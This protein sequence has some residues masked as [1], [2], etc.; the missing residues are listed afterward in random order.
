MKCR[1]SSS[2]HP[3]V[4][5]EFYFCPSVSLKFALG[6]FC[7]APV[8]PHGRTQGRGQTLCC[9]LAVGPVPGGGVQAATANFKAVPGMN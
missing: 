1:L 9:F 2:H 8:K 6:S 5:T 3:K 7:A 4:P